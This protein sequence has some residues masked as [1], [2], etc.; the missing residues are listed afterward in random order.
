MGTANPHCT[1]SRPVLQEQ[2]LRCDDCDV[3]CALVVSVLLSTR[4][5]WDGASATRLALES[6]TIRN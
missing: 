5:A 2:G 4:S 6:Y 1:L 3:S